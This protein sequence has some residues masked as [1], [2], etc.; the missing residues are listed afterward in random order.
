VKQRAVGGV[1]TQK[2]FLS[3]SSVSP[4]DEA[5]QSGREG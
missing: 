5:K 3:E 2:G 1:V 4:E